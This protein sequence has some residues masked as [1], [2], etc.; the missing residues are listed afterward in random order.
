VFLGEGGIYCRQLLEQEQPVGAP[1]EEL[2]QATGTP[3][4]MFQ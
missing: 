2:V 3:L 1:S 4:F